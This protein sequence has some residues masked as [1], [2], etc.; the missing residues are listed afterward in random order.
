V[1]RAMEIEP[2]GKAPPA[3]ED[4]RFGANANAKCD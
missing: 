1:E 3:L 4:K 2:E